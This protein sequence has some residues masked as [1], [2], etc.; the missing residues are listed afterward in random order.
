MRVGIGRHGIVHRLIRDTMRLIAHGARALERHGGREQ[1][2][3]HARDGRVDPGLERGHPHGDAQHHVDRRGP[4]ADPLEPE[5]PRA[6]CDRDGQSAPRDAPG[7]EQRQD[8]DGADV[9]DDRERQEERLEVGRRAP[10]RERQDT[11]R[12]RRVGGH[13]DTPSPG[14]LAPRID[15][16]IQQGRDHHAAERRNHREGRRLDLA[17]LAG[18]QL[19][20]DLQAHDQEEQRE[21]PVVHPMREVLGDGPPPDAD[22]QRGSPQLLV[23]VTPRRVGPRQRHDRRGQEE[24]AA[25]GFLS[26]ERLEGLKHSPRNRALGPR[27]R[28]PQAGVLAGGTRHASSSCRPGFPARP[29]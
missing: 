5:D 11:Q 13:G 19:P 20:L 28:T 27:P 1:P 26:E 3:G 17:E 16:E 21:Q 10:G 8:E 12:E 4:D 9:V 7:I 14:S 25:G 24:H 6:E 18:H 2:E 22:G 23:G 15:R 29:A